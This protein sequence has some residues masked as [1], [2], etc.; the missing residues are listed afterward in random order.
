MP[1]SRE[2]ITDR[3]VQQERDEDREPELPA[4]FLFFHHSAIS[5]C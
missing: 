4:L 1:E 5:R 2:R 3:Q